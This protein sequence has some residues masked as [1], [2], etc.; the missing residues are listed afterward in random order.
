ML[1]ISL[2]LIAENFVALL[3]SGPFQKRGL[4]FFKEDISTYYYGEYKQDN[5]RIEVFYTESFIKPQ[6]NWT[7]FK[8]TKSRYR[9]F[10]LE[11]NL[12]FIPDIRTQFG[13]FILVPEKYE[14]TCNFINIFMERFYYFYGIY[15]NSYPIPLPAVL[16]F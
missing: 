16:E 2:P 5:N 11:D 6:E 7:N 15:G 14:N 9:L 13:I 4:D 10:K 12:I 1:L 8:C 3:E